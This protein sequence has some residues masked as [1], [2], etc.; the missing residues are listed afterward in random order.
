MDKVIEALKKSN[1]ECDS[2][3]DL[4]YN[5]L[6]LLEIKRS[7][8]ALINGRFTTLDEFEREMEAEYGFCITT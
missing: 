1:T 6:F 7:E 3:Y 8:K 4:L 2:I 5:M